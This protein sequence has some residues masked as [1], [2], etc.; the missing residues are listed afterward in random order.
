MTDRQF[1]LYFIAFFTALTTYGD[2]GTT[3]SYKFLEYG[4]GISIAVTL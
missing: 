3:L 2:F 1:H 4:M